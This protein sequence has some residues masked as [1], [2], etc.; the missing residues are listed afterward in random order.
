MGVSDATKR[1]SSHHAASLLAARGDV[2]TQSPIVRAL[3]FTGSTEIGRL[4][5]AKS[6][7]TVEG[8]G[9]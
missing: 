1:R 2:I 5:L 8:I 4:L 9:F 6:A 7:G 3:S